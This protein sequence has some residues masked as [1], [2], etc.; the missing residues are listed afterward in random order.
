MMTHKISVLFVDD[1]INVLAAIR[2]M[3][4]FKSSDWKMEFVESGV[5]ALKLFEQT[6]FD[7]VVSDIR[8]PGMDGAE[9]LTRIK[10]LYPGVILIALSGQVDL[11]EVIRSIRAVH[12]YISK[13]C[14][15]NELVRKIE[16]AIKSR[17]ILTDPKMQELV[18]ELDALPVLPK[19]F[20][21]IDEELRLDEPSIEKI[22]DLITMDVGLVAKILKLV[23]SPY[24]G[25][26]SHIDSLFQ[27]I[28]ML[29]LETIKALILSTYMFSMYDE[30]KLPDLSL[31]LLW[32]HSFRVSNIARLIAQCEGADK[33]VIVQARMAGLL[34]DVGK[35][36]LASSFPDR[37]AKV[38]KMVAETNAPIRDCEME[39]FG[40][41][42]AHLGAYLM[43]LWGLSAEVVHGIGSHHHYDTYDLSIPMLVAVADS[44]DHHC[45]VIHPDYVRI[46]LNKDILPEDQSGE[47]L[48]K[49]I[50]YVKDHWHG[51]EEFQT[52]D[53][54]M[55]FQLRA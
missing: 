28:T 11:N 20:Q 40:T 23:N 53:A 32:E 22:A 3:L 14:E 8:M 36:L 45:V 12:Q 19:V 13:P 25:L 6:K 31:N 51:M 9:L 41:T 21:S 33:E 46:C 7:V 47:L 52:L 49:W 24:F 30:N 38:L 35:L 16:G 26:P 17:D 44:I 50:W 29:G 39:I 43:G 48:E 2:R 34:H 55:I 42:H 18:T 15:T 1:E 4:R 54:D 37:Y 27:A 10:D 5:D